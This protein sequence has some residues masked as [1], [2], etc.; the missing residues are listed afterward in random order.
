MNGTGQPRT[1]LGARRRVNARPKTIEFE[2]ETVN[3]GVQVLKGYCKGR[4]EGYGPCP[5]GVTIEVGAAFD[6]WREKAYRPATD[7]ER[8]IWDEHVAACNEKGEDPGESPINEDGLIFAGSQ[9]ARLT[10]HRDLLMAVM[11]GLDPQTASVL[12]GEDGDWEVILTDLGWYTPTPVDEIAGPEGEGE[13]AASPSTGPSSS[14]ESATS[15]A[16]GRARS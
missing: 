1:V 5:T 15:T 2:V 6:V 10:L 9:E 4:P 3:D 13:A 8:Q 7:K 11:P 12:A 16:S 14:P